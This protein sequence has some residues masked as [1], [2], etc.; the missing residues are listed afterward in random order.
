MKKTIYLTLAIALLASCQKQDENGDLGG[1]W[2]L[3]QIEEHKN[4]TTIV[5]REKDLFWSIQLNLLTTTNGGK[6]RFQHTGDSLYIQMIYSPTNAREIG[7]YNPKDER[8][9]VKHLNR[10]RM[11]LQSEEVTL[12]F[13]KF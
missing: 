10:S 9:G 2:K 6:G 12:T 4:D 8:F 7:M 11:V 1:F 3:L 5:T 13:R